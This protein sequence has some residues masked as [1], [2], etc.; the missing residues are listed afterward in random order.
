MRLA[1]ALGTFLLLVF[2]QASAQDFQKGWKASQ[3]GDYVTAMK[4]WE[5]LAKKGNA[6]AQYNLGWIY[7]RGKGVIQDYAEAVKWY[8]LSANQGYPSAQ[9]SLGVMYYQGNSVLKDY[10]E[11]VKWYRL[12]A[13]QGDPKAQNNLGL[14]YYAGQGVLKDNLTAH[15]WLNIASANGHDGAGKNR[16]D[17]AAKMTAEDISKATAIARECV[18]R[19]YKNC[20]Y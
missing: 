11:A 14:M 2:T 19:N 3:V 5:P 12:S 6:T 17:I 10:A 8:L 20:G 1:L 16:D 4:E 13:E 18:K 9:N 15:M 7:D